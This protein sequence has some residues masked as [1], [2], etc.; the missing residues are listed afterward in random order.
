MD[1]GRDDPR[2]A[3][4]S[5][6]PRMSLYD[7]DAPDTGDDAYEEVLRLL[8]LELDDVRAESRRLMDAALRSLDQTVTVLDR[9]H[10]RG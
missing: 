3:P 5:G 9:H 8:L 6:R 1:D 4:L 2:V 7:Q 10:R